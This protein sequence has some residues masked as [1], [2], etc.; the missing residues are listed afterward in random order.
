[1]FSCVAKKN[2]VNY[3]AQAVPEIL[4]IEP[5][6][7]KATSLDQSIII[8]GYNTGYTLSEIDSI[9]EIMMGIYK[10]KYAD[11]T[12]IEQLLHVIRLLLT[13]PETSDIDFSP[14]K[15]LPQL[16][17]IRIAGRALT[18]IPDLS[19]I[20]SL[21]IL[22][23]DYTSLTSLNGLEKIPQLEGLYIEA[24]YM[25]ITDTSTLR[26]LEN[27][28]NFH[29]YNSYFNIDFTNLTYSPMLEEIYFSSIH[30]ELDLKG[31]GQLRQLKKLRLEIGVSKETGEQDVFRNIQE[32]GRM[33]GLKELYLNEVITSVGFL[34]NN[35]N[36]EYLVLIAGWDRRDYG[37]PLI[38]LD[39]APLG[40]L[41]KLKHLAI[42]GFDLKN[43]HVL[44]TLP[45]LETL[46]TDLYIRK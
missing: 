38:P 7:E 44:E 32:I 28:Q 27:M 2:Q 12:G 41:R 34:A 33:T 45:E 20:P 1:L 42:R 17:Y 25:P 39:V 14:L 18:E 43:A 36:L 26:Y 29:V 30:R 11:F 15:S 3:Q 40:N 19:N 4:K 8:G 35:I 9:T 31:I 23:L 21:V 37:E 6:S 24:A 10:P 16:R 22:E 46:D 13:L 5:L